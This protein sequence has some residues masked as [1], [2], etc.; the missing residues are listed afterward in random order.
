M[1]RKEITNPVAA[2]PLRV[3]VRDA[4]RVLGISQSQTWKR[5]ASGEIT[6]VKDGARTL[7][8]MQEL[9]RYSG[10]SAGA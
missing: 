2:E 1:T 10:T 9:R 6:V 5:I 4:A 8:T 7:V 3:G